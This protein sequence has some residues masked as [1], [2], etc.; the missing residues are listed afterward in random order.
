MGEPRSS[1]AIWLAIRARSTLGLPKSTQKKNET[2]VW[3]EADAVG[4]N[5]W[6]S[7]A[8]TLKVSMHTQSKH[9]GVVL[10][11][12]RTEHGLSNERGNGER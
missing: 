8:T 4:P 12:E 9:G 5:I 1:D 10:E 3:S 6:N 7:S 11:D 2:R